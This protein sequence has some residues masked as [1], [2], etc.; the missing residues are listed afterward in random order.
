MEQILDSYIPFLAMILVALVGLVGLFV[1]TNARKKPSKTATIASPEIS[2]SIEST[3]VSK[4]NSVKRRQSTNPRLS[5]TQPNPINRQKL[6]D[7]KAEAEAK[8]KSMSEALEIY[9]NDIWQ[10]AGI[11][12]VGMKRDHNEDSWGMAEYKANRK[13]ACGLYVVADGM[14]GHAGGEVASQITVDT[15]KTEF[16]S[17]P[18]TTENNFETWLRETAEMANQAVIAKQA[19]QTQR[20]K[21]GST[22]VMALICDGKTY[23]ANVGDSR[24]Y[25]LN[26]EIRRITNDHSLVERLVELGQITP[27]EARHHPQRNVIYSTMG[28]PEKMHVDVFTEPLKPGDRLLLC[29]DGLS[30]MIE[31][32]DILSISKSYTDPAKACQSMIEIA[33]ANG[34]KDN[35]TAVIIQ[36]N[37][38]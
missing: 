4:K 1:F 24:A 27:E 18:P 12:D 13:K 7:A 32:N 10:V 20:E 34:G 2:S 23:I 17:H 14:G 5:T 26:S 31:D 6:L 3:V 25:L 9:A 38:A 15:V 8:Q 35:I 11:T 29:S 16:D 28:D 37:N 22:L 33:N 30:T 19:T 21:M 36:M